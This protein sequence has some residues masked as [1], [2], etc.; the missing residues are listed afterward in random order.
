MKGA[1]VFLFKS[2]GIGTAFRRSLPK[3]KLGQDDA[4]ENDAAAHVSDGQNLLIHPPA[5]GGDQIPKDTAHGGKHRL[6]GQDDGGIG[7]CRVFLSEHLQGI[8]HT[9][10]QQSAEQDGPFGVPYVSEGGGLGAHTQKQAQSTAVLAYCNGNYPLPVCYGIS[11]F[12]VNSFKI[13]WFS[14]IQLC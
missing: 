13:R 12:R 4:C 3:G 5:L 1:A 14:Y 8:C 9:H 10:R 11:V 6:G 2:R 7:G